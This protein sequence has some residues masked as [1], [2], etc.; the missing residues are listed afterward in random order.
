M[1]TFKKLETGRWQAQ[2]ARQ[3]VRKAKSFKTKREAQDW[4]NRQEFLITEGETG[5]S[6][7]LLRELFSRYAREVSPKKRGARWEIIRLE[8]LSKDKIS[9]IRLSDLA[10]SDFADWRDRRLS[11]VAPAS[12][13]REMVLMSSVLTQARRE[14]GLISSNPMTDVRK[15]SKPPSRDRRVAQDE[16]DKLVAAAG[17]DLTKIRARAVHAFLFAIETAMRSGEIIS[18]TKQTVDRENRVATLPK[19]KNGTSRKVPLS[20]AALS[21]LSELPETEGA[22]F[23]LT[24]Q[25][26]DAN[27]RAARDKA[28][29]KDLTFHDSRHEA[30]TRLA[31]KLDVLSL[32]RMVG[33]RDIRM[34]Q[35]YY[36][37]TPEELARRL[38]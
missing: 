13:S 27:F 21:L 6:S 9:E 24:S 17:V 33:H 12:V 3:G 30:I 1:A 34:L 38:D 10:P 4:A 14:W 25:Q 23:G 16:V 7:Q 11:E 26:I 32:A 19:T 2:V 35:V 28:E 5:G 31:K 29:I 20:S 18:L 15:P 37:E 8:R 22:L 36:N